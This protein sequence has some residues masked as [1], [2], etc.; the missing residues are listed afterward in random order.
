LGIL[1]SEMAKYVPDIKG[2]RWLILAPGRF[3]KPV[4]KNKQYT[5]TTK[6]GYKTA[7]EC[8]F[9]LGNESGTPPEIDCIRKDDFWLVRT[10]ANKYPITDIHE[11]IVHNPDHK[12][13]LEEYDNREILSLFQMYQKRLKALSSQGVPILF[14]NYGVSAGTSLPHP[15]SQVIVLPHQI[16]LESLFLEPVKNL[17]LDNNFFVLYCPDFSQYPYEAW[18]TSKECS[19]YELNS[20]E[21]AE[22]KL[23]KFNNEELLDLGQMLQKTITGLKK[24]LGE[25]D[26]N[27]YVSPKPPFYLRLIPRIVTR[28]GFELGTGLSTNTLD[29][30]E[31][32]AKLKQVIQ[33]SPRG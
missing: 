16:N 2:H 21:L 23:E 33:T 15:H 29:P 27:Y 10:F 12:K 4:A 20:P 6:K 25:F 8:P 18:I 28:G 9:C 17:V 7:Q 1:F 26:Y 5:F 24:I 30:A 13:E 3:N 19:K 14:R 31:A 22:I 11:V 32:A